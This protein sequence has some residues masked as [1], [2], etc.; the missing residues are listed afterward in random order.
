M[1]A[2]GDGACLH[3]YHAAGECDECGMTLMPKDVWMA[4]YAKKIAS[5]TSDWR[6]TVAGLDEVY[7]CENRS[8]PDHTLKDYPAP[9]RCEIDGA[10]L[11]HKNRFEFQPTWVCLTEDCADNGKVYYTSG[12]CPTCGQPVQSMGHMDH[13]PIHGGL[14]FMAENLFHHVEGTLPAAGE[15]RLFFYDD[16]KRPLDP[17]NFTANVSIERFDEETEEISS[18]EYEVALESLENGYFTARIPEGLEFPIEVTAVVGLA[19][20]DALFTFFFDELSIEPEPGDQAGRARL[21]AHGERL[22]VDV[23][24]DPADVVREIVRR[25]FIIKSRIE[26]KDWFGMHVPAYDTIDLAKGLKE[27]SLG[28]R[29]RDAKRFFD[30]IA[31]LNLA[32][33]RLDRA[34]DAQDQGRVDNY[35]KTYSDSLAVL[36]ELFPD[37]R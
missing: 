2:V 4:K 6:L 37:A 16:W 22:P 27:K 18:D 20:E 32:S 33:D 5:G 7:W 35:Y 10:P 8:N 11:V 26:A 23:P 24:E 9:G 14:L 21:H 28:L 15:F 12:T 29:G 13:N 19:G 30:A 31:G 3:D 34:G 25:D 17:R 36:L 1:H